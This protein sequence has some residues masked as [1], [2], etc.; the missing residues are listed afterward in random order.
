MSIKNLPG[1]AAAVT[2]FFLATNL[3][4]AV[5]LENNQPFPI[6][7]PV[8]VRNVTPAEKSEI[9]PLTS[10]VQRLGDDAVFIADV[11]ANTHK[12]ASFTRGTVSEPSLSIRPASNG[13]DLVYSGVELGRLSWDILVSPVKNKE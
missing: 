11:P 12:T 9:T 6:H 4:R 1:V 5:V 7:M 8:R 3:V 13:V 2:A 10:C